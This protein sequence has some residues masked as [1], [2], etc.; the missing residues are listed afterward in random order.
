LYHDAQ[1]KR[2]RVA[3]LAFPSGE[4]ISVFDFP[5]T[6][7]H[8]E[9]HWSPDGKSIHFVDTH[10]GVSNIWAL[11]TETGASRQVTEFLSDQI[12]HFAWSHDGQSLAV[13]RGQSTSDIVML[14]V[15]E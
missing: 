1:E 8:E 2:D 6:A 14:T 7:S 5:L 13:V 12:F 4:V 3:I 9:F 11:D 15:T 10:E